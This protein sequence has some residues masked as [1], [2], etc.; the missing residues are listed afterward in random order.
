MQNGSQTY[1]ALDKVLGILGFTSRTQKG[2]ARIYRNETAGAAIILPDIPFEQEVLPHHL[3]VVRHNLKDL[4]EQLIQVYR[5]QHPE[6][7]ETLE[8]A[9][10]RLYGPEEDRMLLKIGHAAFVIRDNKVEKEL[11]VAELPPASWL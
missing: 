6:E 4:L 8:A 11:R 3:T 9:P 1:G 5:T 7:S 2:K 10:P